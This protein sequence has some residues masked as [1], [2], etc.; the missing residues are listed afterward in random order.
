MK[1]REPS[2]AT[3][4]DTDHSLRGAAD[5][6]ICVPPCRACAAPRAPP[7]GRARSPLVYLEPKRAAREGRRVP[8]E[9]S[10]ASASRGLGPR[11]SGSPARSARLDGAARAWRV[12]R[13]WAWPGLD[14]AYVALTRSQTRGSC[15]SHGH[16][17]WT[18]MVLGG[19]SL[20]ARVS[21]PLSRRHLSGCLSAEY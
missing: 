2:L 18:W 21:I 17:T 3:R 5:C 14:V 19:R 16:G 13:P 20:E 9:P 11:R 15:L 4:S 1:A 6:V 7:R 10:R 12:A 8:R